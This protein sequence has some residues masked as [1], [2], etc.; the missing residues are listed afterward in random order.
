M[1]TV[2]K[3][4]RVLIAVVML[5]SI[6]AACGSNSEPPKASNNGGNASPNPSASESGKPEG[7]KGKIS[8]SMFDRGQVAAD[9]GT[10][11]SNRWT[12]WINENSPT[13]VEWIP[14]PRNEA[15]SKLNAL[16]ASGE[17]PD[18]IWE[19]DRNYMTQL[20]AQ[21]AIQPIGE[22]IEKY[23]T[24]YKAYLEKNA[25]LKPYLTVD[26]KIYAIASKRGIDGIANHAMW[27]RQDILDELGLSAPTTIDELIDLARKVKEKDPSMT[28]IVFNGNGHGIMRALY[29]A[30][31]DQWYLE[32]GKMVYARTL[33]RYAD[34]MAFQKLLFDEGLIDREYIT[35]NNF[36][37]SKQI[38][39]TGKAAIMLGAWDMPNEYRDMMQNV[40]TAQPV[41]LEPP[42]TAL[43]KTGL[44][45][46]TPA[47]I[48]VM[49]NSEMKE[50]QIKDAIAFLDWLIED[51]WLVLK[52][53][54]ENEHHKL[55]NGIPQ[56]INADVFRKE[57]SYASEYAVIHQ[58]SPEPSWYPVLA[59][60]DEL[61]QAYA[62]LQTI[63]I[64]TALKNKFRR[65]IAYNPDLPELS[66]LIATFRPIAE[67]IETKVAT[68]GNAMTPE[69]GLEELR[70][71]WKRLGGENIEG[72]VQEWYE[73]NKENL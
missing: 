9:E 35:D 16:I 25:E 15:Q 24:S 19:Y 65:D 62:K 14:V 59:A 21:G 42:A 39:I 49:F 8:V 11:E 69:Q 73:A 12:K 55:E 34:S 40:P 67:Q 6:L 64:E 72:L 37:R 44:Y 61:S 58:W 27:V 52:K 53:G 5:V 66:Q 38:W 13:E 18:L 36:E 54:F 51:N 28:P 22:Y 68:G 7:K 56:I 63:S 31:S 10:Y 48:Y 29:Q 30:A 70:K 57:A 60:Q 26:N 3:V 47:N 23:S 41:P 43:G 45:Q 32:D 71:E 2:N 17:A 33:D 46:E 50:E 20:A 4:S 1:K